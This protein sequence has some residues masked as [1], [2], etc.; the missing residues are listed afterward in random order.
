MKIVVSQKFGNLPIS[1]SC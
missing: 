1:K